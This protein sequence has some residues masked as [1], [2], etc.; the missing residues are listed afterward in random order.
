MKARLRAATGDD[1]GAIAGVIVAAGR[2][3]W[4]HIGPVERLTSSAAD[5]EPRLAAAETALV[6][7]DEADEVVG[8]A[9]TGGCELQFLHVH[10]RAWG[11]GVGRALLEAGEDALRSAGCREATLYTEERNH[12]ALRLYAA[13]GWH[14]DGAVRERDWL[15]SPIREPRLSK[16]LQSFS[17]SSAP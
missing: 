7:V 4:G 1:L 12:R 8:F 16:R 9:L 10:P 14:P 13:A 15:G 5:W 17:A 6:A 3:A 2:A 11:H